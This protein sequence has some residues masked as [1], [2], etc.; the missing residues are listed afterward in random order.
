L[1]ILRFYP[2]MPGGRQE[3]HER[4]VRIP[5]P[6]LEF[7]LDTF[8]ASKIHYYLASCSVIS[9]YKVR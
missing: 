9:D 5:G 3:N 6:H 1:P 4:H 2:G 7:E 8:S